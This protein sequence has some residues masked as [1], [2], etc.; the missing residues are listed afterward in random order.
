MD[1]IFHLPVGVKYSVTKE[2]SA[3]EDSQSNWILPVTPMAGAN[4]Y[5]V[6]EGSPFPCSHTYGVEVPKPP[7][8]ESAEY[9]T[10]TFY[11]IF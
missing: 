2:L 8:P 1:Y 9:D 4:P 11:L 6:A 10:A 7:S 3:T 5:P